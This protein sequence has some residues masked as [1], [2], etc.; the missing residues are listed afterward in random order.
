[1]CGVCLPRDYKR[2]EDIIYMIL[3]FKEKRLVGSVSLHI[4][5]KHKSRV[6]CDHLIV[7]YKCQWR[8]ALLG[9]N[10]PLLKYMSFGVEYDWE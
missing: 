7:S 2:L 3:L 10:G 9:L 6:L 4:F 5:E 8:K 1:M